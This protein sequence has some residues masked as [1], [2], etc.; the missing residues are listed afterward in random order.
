MT[1]HNHY[2]LAEVLH[3]CVGAVMLSS[4]PSEMYDRLYADWNR[5]ECNAHSDG[6]RDRVEVLWLNPKCAAAQY[7]QRMFA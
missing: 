3:D 1:D 6:A 5:R 2:G 7:Q 4:Y